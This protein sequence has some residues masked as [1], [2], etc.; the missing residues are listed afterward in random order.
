VVDACY[1]GDQLYLLLNNGTTSSAL[2]NLNTGLTQT[3]RSETID[4]IA[5]RSASLQSDGS[6]IICGENTL[7]GISYINFIQVDKDGGVYYGNDVFR[8]FQGSV[9]KVLKTNDDGLILVG[10][11]GS[12][13]GE[14]IQLIKT[15]KDNFMLKN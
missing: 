13:F 11:T 8:T 14:T 5:G 9:G 1:S 2:E 10:T 3:W 6:L 7:E 4:G 15:D 12:T